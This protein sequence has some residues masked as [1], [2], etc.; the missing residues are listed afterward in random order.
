MLSSFKWSKEQ[1]NAYVCN[2]MKINNIQQT[3]NYLSW[4]WVIVFARFIALQ[5]PHIVVTFIFPLKFRYNKSLISFITTGKQKR[6]WK[7]IQSHLI[8]LTHRYKDFKHAQQAFFRNK[9]ILMQE[10]IYISYT[11]QKRCGKIEINPIKKKM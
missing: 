4:C 6:N 8:S 10:I 1:F 2:W 5:N 9:S 3:M 7:C 11:N